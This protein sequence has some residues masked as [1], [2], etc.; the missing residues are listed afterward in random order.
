MTSPDYFEALY[1][2]SADPWQLAE[3][4]YELR[5]FEV[6]AACLPR[7]R[8]GRAFEPGCSI[9][10]LTGL[11]ASRCDEI[12][13]MD[14]IPRAVTSARARNDAPSVT[15]R[16][17]S[18]PADW[19]AQTF[20]LIVISEM[21]YYLTAADRERVSALSLETLATDGHLVL[22]HWR[23]PFEEAQ[24]TGDRAHDEVAAHGEWQ[25]VVEHIEQDFRLDI[26]TRA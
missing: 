12:L 17:G 16:A 4:D 11:L 24:C 9:G 14:Q 21:L 20:D 26:F 10:V 3:R 22:V 23:H 2:Q 18:V 6:T 13:A 7:R 25:R 15:V 8:Y 1:E 5:K 19:P